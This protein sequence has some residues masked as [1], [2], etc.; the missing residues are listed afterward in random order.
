MKPVGWLAA[1][2]VSVI[3]FPTVVPAADDDATSKCSAPSSAKFEDGK[4]TLTPGQ[5]ICLRLSS[6]DGKVK[7][8]QAASDAPKN[9]VIV[10]EMS[11]EGES[12]MLVVHNG[13]PKVIKYRAQMRPSGQ[14]KWYPTSICPVQAGLMSFEQWPHGIE[15]MELSDFRVLAQDA[16]MVC[17]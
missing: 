15:T 5:V 13:T 17:D 9:E 3:A 4:V 7:F 10:A 2:I 12:T 6:V 1:I 11:S 8:T 14:K 16:N